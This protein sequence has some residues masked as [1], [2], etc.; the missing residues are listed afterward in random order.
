M[1]DENFE[2]RIALVREPIVEQLREGGRL[3]QY[4]HFLQVDITYRE[5]IVRAQ[6]F[7]GPADHPPTWIVRLAP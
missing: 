2:G 1:A 4:G 3:A 7:V 6:F 5:I